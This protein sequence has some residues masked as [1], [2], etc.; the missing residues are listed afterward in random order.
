MKKIAVG[1]SGGVDSSV[2]ALL[3]KR[4]GYEV[5][6]LT[7]RIYGGQ[8]DSHG[9]KGPESSEKASADTTATSPTPARPVRHACFGP[10]EDE[11]IEQARSVA[12]KIG[13]PHHVIDLRKDYDA[14][15]LEYF[16][17]EYTE[18]RTPNPCVV[19]NSSMKFGL[20]VDRAFEAGI[21][22]EG[23]ATGHYARV[24]KNGTTGM[25][26][27]LRALDGTKDQS[28][29]LY[30]LTQKQLSRV[31]F[32]L[33][34]MIKVDV[35]AIAREAGLEVEADRQESQNFAC[36]DYAD[37]IRSP[38][39]PGDFVNGDGEVLGRHRGLP[40][41]TIG[42]RRGIGISSSSEPLYV[43]RLD[44]KHNRVVL[45]SE[46]EIYGTTLTAW[47]V[48]WTSGSPISGTAKMEAKIRS[49]SRQAMATVETLGEGRIRVTFEKPQLAI[50]PGQSVVLYDGETVVAGGIIEGA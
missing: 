2:A 4:A 22:F 7:M 41:Y 21:D 26:E 13:I 29:F 9:E 23:F 35:K 50:T 3:L 49:Q 28:Y 33:G 45:G 40:R 17:S 18:G 37:L 10:N 27:L 20:L 47:D 46:S 24:R 19:C 42:Q 15:V 36:G 8:L 1:M 12:E 16:S 34:E 5:V 31:T 39:E 32:P 38:I 48:R 14:T 11:E 44:A 30:R 43:I 6:G 25:T